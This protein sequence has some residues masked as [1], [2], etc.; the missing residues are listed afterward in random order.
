MTMQSKMP[1]FQKVIILE[2]NM[3]DNV[4]K[5]FSYLLIMHYKLTKFQTSW[6]YPNVKIFCCWFFIGD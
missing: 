4:K 1:K 2:K 5:L 3:A 6:K